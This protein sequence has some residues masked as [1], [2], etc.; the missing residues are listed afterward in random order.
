MSTTLVRSLLLRQVGGVEE[1]ESVGEA[2]GGATSPGQ[3]YGGSETEDR[4]ETV[5]GLGGATGSFRDHGPNQRQEEGGAGVVTPAKPPQ[6]VTENVISGV[7]DIPENTASDKPDFQEILSK[8]DAEISKFD[9]IALGSCQLGPTGALEQSEGQPIRNNV[10]DMGFTSELVM[11]D[12]LQG[13]P[14]VNNGKARS[15]KRLAQDRNPIDAQPV[16]TVKKR[17]LREKEDGSEVLQAGSSNPEASKTLWNDIWKLKIG[18]GWVRVVGYGGGWVE[19]HRL[20]V[21]YG[22]GRIGWWWANRLWVMAVMAV[23]ELAG[24]GRIDCGLWRWANRLVVGESSVMANLCSDLGGGYE[25]LNSN[26]WMRA[27]PSWKPNPEGW[28]RNF[29]IQKPLY[30]GKQTL[31]SLGLFRECREMVG[32]SLTRPELSWRAKSCMGG[33]TCHR[34]HVEDG[35]IL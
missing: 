19:F 34:K 30:M 26:R 10:E 14:L 25:A 11:L 9:P 7:A 23:G 2:S 31:W 35:L 33:R 24:G 15:W 1:E 32:A 17:S 27:D 12:S 18:G 6:Y 20:I 8:I 3:P 4:R 5:T 22:G 28:K 16:P 29:D 21:G 13:S